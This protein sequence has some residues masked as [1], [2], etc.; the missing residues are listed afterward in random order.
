MAYLYAYQSI[1]QNIKHVLSFT[2]KREEKTNSNEKI[3]HIVDNPQTRTKS[4]NITTNSP[5][6]PKTNKKT[7]N[8]IRTKKTQNQIIS[9][10][11]IDRY[12]YIYVHTYSYIYKYKY[13]HTSITQTINQSDIIA[14]C[15]KRFSLI[16][17]VAAHQILLILCG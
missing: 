2:Q 6:H 1:N 8:I 3:K 10:M 11:C 7:Q 14:I 13:V 5:K 9:Y 12:I 4:T 16:Q 17:W 15:F